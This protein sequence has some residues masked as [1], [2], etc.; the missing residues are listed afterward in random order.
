MPPRIL[1]MPTSMRRFLVASCLAEVTQQIHSFRANGAISAQR[2]LAV[3]LDSIA[4]RKSTGSLWTVPPAIFESS[5]IERACFAQRERDKPRQG[6]VANTM[7]LFRDGA[8]GSSDWFGDFVVRLFS[9]VLFLA[10]ATLTVEI[11]D[12]VVTILWTEERGRTLKPK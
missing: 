7:N 10:G 9:A 12:V 3:E 6:V 4:L 1:L 11:M 8:V 5:Y 2:L